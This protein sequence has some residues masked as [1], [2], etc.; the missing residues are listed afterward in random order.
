MQKVISINLNGQ[1]YQLDESGY[2]T[3]REYLAHAEQQLAANPDRAEIMADLEQAVADKC[4]R[5]LG[6]HKSVVTAGEVN[7]I[8]AE[9]G[10]V[11]TASAEEAASASTSAGGA[12]STPKKEET[13]KRL[14]RIGQGAVFAGVCNGIAAFL[15]VDVTLVRIVFVAAAL[16]TKGVGVVAYIILIFLVP[17]ANTPEAVAAAAGTPFT[18]KDVIDR[19]TKAAANSSRYFRRQWRQ[20]RREWRHYGWPPGVPPAFSPPPWAAAVLPLFG[21][22]H[23]ALFLIM[24]AMLISLVNT[25]GVL[26]WELPADVPVWAAVLVVLI[27]YQI[28][29]SPFRALQHWFMFPRPGL[30]P[31]WFSFWNAV[32]CLVGLA[33]VVW[34]ASNHIPEIREF[35]QRMPD[36]FRD[37][38]GAIRDVAER[39]HSS[40][41]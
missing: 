34:T 37:F 31:A 40:R 35:L 38:A 10:P 13:P 2:E 11:D 6:P 39:Y 32:I 9:M 41:R 7:Q 15:H 16:L 23:L 30:Q 21:L 24:A 19:G 25:G 33:L 4:Q 5:Y 20:Q 3:L 26:D 28:V 36:L 22:V 1:V 17:E 8:V 14:Y 12:K 18:A 27:G 29:V